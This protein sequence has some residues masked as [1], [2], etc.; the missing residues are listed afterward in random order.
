MKGQRN[1]TGPLRSGFTTGTCAAL[2]ASAAATLLLDGERPTAV[3]LITPKGTRITCVPE[4]LYLEGDTAVCSIRK[5]AGDDPDVTDG[6]LICA[7]VRRAACGIRIEGGK[8]VG[9]VTK[10][11]LDQ[12]IG[13]AAI[14][15]IPRKMIR[16][17]AE[18]A[19]RELDY[20]GGL[21]VLI[22]VPEGERLAK[23]TFNPMLGI[24]GGISILGT[25]GIV[26]PMSEQALVDTVAVEA[27]QLAVIHGTEKLILVP[28]NYGTD[29]LRGQYPQ[30]RDV[31]VLKCSN[32]IGDALEISARE[33]FRNVLLIGHIGKLVKLAGGI[34][35]THSK[36]AD[37]RRELFCAHAAVWG[38]SKEVCADLMEQTTSDGCLSVLERAGLREPV[39]DALMKAIRKQLLRKAEGAFRIGAVTFSNEYGLLGMTKEATEMLREW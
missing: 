6:I 18:R 36:I 20:S 39:M 1:M 27:H 26:E 24:E 15:R 12:P 31:P 23:K 13:A 35:N 37:C 17:A 4:E 16:Q 33:G 3:S 8:G 22:T 29:F 5:D 14:N 2:A 7:E 32:Y 9:R 38:A 30:L 28:G 19:C 11:G 34:M 10:P 25:S 21:D